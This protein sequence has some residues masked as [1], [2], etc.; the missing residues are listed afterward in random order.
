MDHYADGIW[1]CQVARLYR[2]SDLNRGLI[3]SIRHQQRVQK[4]STQKKLNG[5][6]DWCPCLLQHTKVS[7]RGTDLLHYT[8]EHSHTISHS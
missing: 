1:R 3:D 4:L 5:K 2:M 7:E 6:Q 8:N